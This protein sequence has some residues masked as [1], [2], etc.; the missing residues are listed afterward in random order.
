MSHSRRLLVDLSGTSVTAD[1]REMLAS[2]RFAG[3][4]V[5]GRNIRDHHQLR[6]LLA[7]VRSL[8]G[9][10]FLVAIDQEGGGVL[11]LLDVPIPPAAMALGAAGDVQLTRSVAAATARGL[12]AAGVN[13]NFAPVA[14]VNI[15]PQNPVIADRSFGSDPHAVAEHVAAFTDGLQS[16]G[17]AA[18]AKHFPGHGDTRLDSHLDLPLLDRSPEELEEVELVPF[19]AAVDAGVAAVM[20]A[21]IVFPQLDPDLPATL[22]PHI[23]G[24]LLRQK[25]GF[26]GVVVSDAMDMRAISDR[27]QPEEANVLALRA[28]VDLACNIG[29]VSHHM[30]VADAVEAAGL[31][32][33]T[34][35]ERIARLARDFPARPAPWDEG[36]RALMEQAAARGLVAMGELPRLEPG[37]PVTLVSAAGTYVS[38]AQQQRVSPGADLVQELERA[39]VPVRPLEY[40]TDRLGEQEYVAALLRAV[41]SGPVIFA[42]TS[43]T[44]LPEAEVQLARDLRQVAGERY[45]H[46]ALWNPYHALR[47]PGPALIG[48]GFRQPTLKALVWAL[49]GAPVSGRLPFSAVA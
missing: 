49:L 28:G 31:D 8:A 3:I 48:F 33:A 23:I 27:F 15:N 41:G 38:S 30:K 14:D 46:V 1:E 21:H 37:V 18:T 20:T 43:R 40:Q 9:D 16:A 10:D 19:R 34:S 22:S 17:V 47:V 42:S 25:L 7:E 12:Q 32:S 44:P 36:D 45:V 2:R 35:L 13:L 11:R 24:R 29:S 39:G 26:S 5:F 6:D 4:C